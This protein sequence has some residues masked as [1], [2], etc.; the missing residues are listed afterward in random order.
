MPKPLP[1]ETR[2]H[3]VSRGMKDP[4]FLK[5]MKGK[6]QDQKIGRLEGIYTYHEKKKRGR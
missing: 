6:T 5:T 4:E 3:F 1:K 2:S